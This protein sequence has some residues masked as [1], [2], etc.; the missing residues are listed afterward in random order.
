ML[1]TIR[2][3]VI[4]NPKSDDSLQSLIA[5]FLLFLKQKTIKIQFNKYILKFCCVLMLE[6]KSYVSCLHRIKC[7]T[8]SDKKKKKN[9]LELISEQITSPNIRQDVI[10][11]PAE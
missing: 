1:N 3:P 4:G 7:F 11:D 10:Y 8:L 2:V 9:P 5:I 6:M